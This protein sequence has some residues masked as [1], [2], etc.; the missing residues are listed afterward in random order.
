M[1]AAPVPAQDQSQQPAQ[2]R[3]LS[4][5]MN[6]YVFPSAGQAPDQQSRDEAEC[7][8]WAVGNTGVDPFELQKQ[9]EAQK[10][11]AAQQGQQAQQA[12]QGS[13]ARGAVTGAA[14][15][16]LIGEIAND[17]AGEGAAYG[18]AAGMMRGR[19][20]ARAAQSQAQQQ[21]QQQV[22]QVEANYEQQ[23]GNF[24]NAFSVCLE[25]K[26]YMVRF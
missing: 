24:N 4:A 1:L 26:D 23:I 13:A 12:T 10:Q 20:Q 14:T 16:A 7:Y 17:D 19:R 15:G 18:A 9:A 6:I 3:S 25:A 11:Q 8:E 22:Q 2:Q 5:T 21:T